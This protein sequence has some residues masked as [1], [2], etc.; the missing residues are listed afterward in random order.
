MEIPPEFRW[1]FLLVTFQVRNVSLGSISSEAAIHTFDLQLS[2]GGTAT[3]AWASPLNTE[4][5]VSY[6]V[7]T[8]D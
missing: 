6:R 3:F 5:T 7:A 2:V 1:D 8:Y 4:L